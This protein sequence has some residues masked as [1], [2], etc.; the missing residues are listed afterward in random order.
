MT[1][2]DSDATS[3]VVCI[4]FGLLSNENAQARSVCNIRYPDTMEGNGPKKN[5]PLDPRMG[6]I[7]RDSDCA[8][9]KKNLE[10]PGHF[11]R[12][13]LVWP[14][15]K[16]WYFKQHRIT[17]VLQ[18]ICF[19][20][21]KMHLNQTDKN[22]AKALGKLQP[23]DRMRLLSSMIPKSGTKIRRCPDK[24]C[25]AVL[26]KITE[27]NDFPQILI[28]KPYESFDDEKKKTV[29]KYGDARALAP[30]QTQLI[31][32]RIS[33]EDM[34]IMGFDPVYS[35]PE[36]M[37][38]SVLPVAPP[39]MRPS[40]EFNGRRGEDDL[41]Y[42]YVNII[43]RDETLRK[44]IATYSENKTQQ[45]KYKMDQ[46]YMGLQLQCYLMIENKINNQP[47]NTQRSGKPMCD[48]IN[49]WQGK[50]GRVRR[51]L[52]GKRVNFSARAVITP[53]PSLKI[54]ELG[55]PPALAMKLTYPEM[56]NRF[57]VDRLKKLVENGP[58]Q[59]PGATKIIRHFENGEVERRDLRF[60]TGGCQE[61]TLKYGDLVERYLED[62]DY[63]IFNRQPTLHKMS[64]MCHV[65]KIIPGLTFR[66]NLSVTTPYNADF[67][68]DEM[69]MHV[70]QGDIARAEISELMIVPTQ[71]ISPKSCAPVISLVQDTLLGSAILTRRD[72]FLTKEEIMPLIVSLDHVIASC[73]NALSGEIRGYSVKNL[74][75]SRIPP[76]AILFPK[77][78]WTGKQLFSLLFPSMAYDGNV[79]SI[80]LE[81]ER[82]EKETQEKRL[83]ANDRGVL[84]RGSELLCGFL[85]KRHLGNSGGGLVHVIFNDYC[86]YTAAT[87]LNCVMSVVDPWIQSYGY[88]IGIADMITPS[89]ISEKVT[90][91][92][93]EKTEEVNDTI[94]RAM[95]PLY[96]MKR[97]T[98]NKPLDITEAELEI[99]IN[100]LL[101]ES[102]DIAGRVVIDYMSKS[103]ARTGR[104]NYLS[105]MVSG[106]PFSA[107]SKGSGINVSQISGCGGQQN[108]SG[109]RIAHN[110][111][112]RCLS[113]CHRYDYSASGRG[114]I[115]NSFLKG[116][117][118]KEFWFHAMS[119]REG[120]TDT[121]HKT[122][123]T[124]Y[125]ERRLVK[126]LEDACQKTDGSVR[127][128]VGNLL[129]LKYGD[130][131]FNPCSL[132]L[133]HVRL[134][135]VK[136][137]EDFSRLF[138]LSEE[139]ILSF[140]GLSTEN[141][142]DMQKF[143]HLNFMTNENLI[144]MNQKAR[145]NFFK[146]AS[147]SPK[148]TQS[149]QITLLSELDSYY[150][151]IHTVLNEVHSVRKQCGTVGVG[152]LQNNA[153]MTLPLNISRI[154]NY[155]KK[156]FPY[157]Q[158]HDE[159]IHIIHILYGIFWLF[160][161]LPKLWD[162]LYLRT[163]IISE[164]SPKVVLSFRKI[165]G[166][167]TFNKMSA[168]AW[169]WIL[170]EICEKYQ[171]SLCQSGEMVGVIAAQS[172]GEPCTQLT[173]NTFHSTGVSSKSAVTRGVPRIEEV[174]NV[175][176]KTKTP[177]TYV[178]LKDYKEVNKRYGTIFVNNIQ[179]VRYMIPFITH[180]K[181]KDVMFRSRIR[182]DPDP[183][184]DGIV[185]EHYLF[186]T[187][188]KTQ[189]MEELVYN[190][191]PW[192]LELLLSFTE[193]HKRNIKV[194]HVVK[195]I[196]DIY[197]PNISVVYS[198]FP[199]ELHKTGNG[200]DETDVYYLIRLRI[201]DN[202]GKPIIGVDEIDNENEHD[203]EDMN[204][205][206]DDE[207]DNDDEDEIDN[208]EGDEDEF[209]DVEVNH[210]CQNLQII[211]NFLLQ[212]SLTGIEGMSDI[213]DIRMEREF[214]SEVY[215]IEACGSNLKAILS[216]P[217]VDSEKCY[218]NDIISTYSV[219]GIDA[220]KR[221]LLHEI[222]LVLQDG[223]HVDYRHLGLLTDLMT[224]TGY[225]TRFTRKG[226][227]M[228]NEI[229]PLARSSFEETIGK[230]FNAGLFAETDMLDSVTSN[231]FVGQD[232]PAGTG[233]FDLILNEQMLLQ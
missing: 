232:V 22:F 180:T 16:Y 179:L 26:H 193:M 111:N 44:A 41:T 142:A 159:G 137:K 150:S 49:R 130:D 31:L 61:I 39:P 112:E 170:K 167:V 127:D 47:Q 139:D 52:V 21:G 15:Y 88:S 29:V 140:Y 168:Q 43:K 200:K 132:E 131:G 35:R 4:Q 73:C 212:I 135:T 145:D 85:N 195:R 221:L 28:S 161:S 5:G 76:P 19:R 128:S 126:G 153:Y 2:A 78:L 204:E 53:D 122:S 162:N 13:Y 133:V 191:S 75:S 176:K 125:M 67:D 181:M 175:A 87:F 119:G 92:I 99:K 151:V 100:R 222:K 102:R 69:N 80:Q 198:E 97:V 196:R 17:R 84:I 104:M 55:V 177:V 206:D 98:K 33:N 226:F 82:W 213:G 182:F 160:E 60:M 57:N 107:G 114:M 208:E 158:Q 48:L 68:G 81:Y 109:G 66:L 12:F 141:D 110:S 11:G 215:I 189:Y 93:K 70:P 187:V 166:I 154:R 42:S 40:I 30:M 105:A 77:K 7:N 72:T 113:Y 120:I 223:S 214:G 71:M 37:V 231:I 108:V 155:A 121:A 201:V 174:I 96:I 65:V 117:T 3:K 89:N 6:P 143:Y 54:W 64:M 186:Q 233:S 25:N 124:G 14:V 10:C 229:G 134:M 34:F 225:L 218:S 116:Q 91:S 169:K 129:Q 156:T 190:S 101:N 56:V 228:N 217:F 36:N 149:G 62:G 123:I 94:T 210:D 202:K 50:Y 24:A 184:C 106:S 216:L 211:E 207:I 192:V 185:M 38:T 86:P 32:S 205:G 95:E 152:D 51:N 45:N 157:Q 220:T 144:V 148:Y 138:V 171:K 1:S 172:I 230:F 46:A 224:R 165:N 173:L 115:F 79:S 194:Q 8:T 146:Y 27:D 9:C 74:P 147:V 23:K 90:Q 164:L 209:S 83:N 197:G 103:Y 227:N 188:K 183:L 20:C 59:Y 163:M 219:L 18:M 118:P 199:Q 203:E 178:Y 58:L 63:V 136:N